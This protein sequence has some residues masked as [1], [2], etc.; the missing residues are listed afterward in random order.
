M[1]ESFF[2]MILRAFYRTHFQ[3][4]APKHTATIKG[5]GLI[6][7]FEAKAIAIGVIIIAIALFEINA[8]KITVEMYKIE[9]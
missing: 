8:E 7:K 9:R 5:L 4:D 1:M 2:C 3:F 6:S